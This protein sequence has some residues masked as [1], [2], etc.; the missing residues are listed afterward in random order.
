MTSES[1]AR[2][3]RL[4]EPAARATAGV[5]LHLL[6]GRRAPGGPAPT[7]RGEPKGDAP[8]PLVTAGFGEPVALPAPFG[9]V[10]GTGEFPVG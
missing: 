6:V 2:H 7:L 3:D 8:R 9:L 1:N 5:P 4:G 10:L